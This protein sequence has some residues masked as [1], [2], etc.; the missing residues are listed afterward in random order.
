MKE[1]SM[2][3]AIVSNE[4]RQLWRRPSLWIVQGIMAV[5]PL[6]ALLVLVFSG[7][8][9]P[10]AS[11]DF[12]IPGTSFL[13]L[14]FLIVPIL[15]IPSLKQDQGAIGEILWSSPVD[16]LVHFCAKWLGLWLGLI[17]GAALQL[18]GW[19]LLD[20]FLP[21]VLPEWIW[22]V[23]LGL[24]LL[25]N[26]VGLSLITFLAAFLRSSLAL[27]IAW[28]VVWVWLFY[29]IYFSASLS[30]GFNPMQSM[31]FNNV[32]FS[33][34]VISPSLGLGLSQARV[35][36]MAAWFAG[37]SL[38]AAALGLGITLILDRRQSPRRP[39]SAV[40]LILAGV[41]AL[42]VGFSANNSI[43]AAHDWATSPYDPQVDE[44]RV[45]SQKTD[46][47]IDAADRRISGTTQ[48]V[49]MP[50]KADGISEIVLKLNPGLELTTR[51]GAKDE[52][53]NNLVVRRTGDSVVI[54]V[55]ESAS[56]PYTLDLAWQ[57]K[58]NIPYRAFEMPWKHN[59]APGEYRYT[60][61][62][63]ALQALL[64]RR[65]SFLLRDGDW[66]P[67]PWTTSSH[68]ADDNQVTLRL[69]GRGEM[70][71]ADDGL[72]EGDPSSGETISYQGTLP[73]ALAVVLPKKPVKG[74]ASTSMVS[75]NHL[76]HAR[77][78][79]RTTEQL[80]ALL[81]TPA[82]K[83][84]VVTPYL[85]DLVWSG[86]LLLVPDGSGYYLARPVSWLY[87]LDPNGR[88]YNVVA[89]TT[90]HTLLRAWM[91]QQ[92]SEDGTGYVALLTPEGYDS[93]QA[94]LSAT[95]PEEWERDKGH[96]LQI[97]EKPD[98]LTSWMPRKQTTL[99]SEGEWSSLAFW[100]AMEMADEQTRQK[101]LELI[102]IFLG[103]VTKTIGG[104][105]RYSM[106]RELLWP[107]VMEDAAAQQMALSLH[108]WAESVGREQA[109]E[110]VFAQLRQT[111]ADDFDG[112]VAELESLSGQPIDRREE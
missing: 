20:L 87:Q 28:V 14:Q 99:T 69:A 107:Y 26:T 23:S 75:S 48:L 5:L 112:F 37:V 108:E 64:D 96:W 16:A 17:P 13:V 67:W 98:Y 65:I 8:P 95:N 89:R 10:V 78:F 105:D 85:S 55:P 56:A 88:D 47:E 104:G 111:K 25:V 40:V 43:R 62:P 9:T 11:V 34:L 109:V 90:M 29:D 19:F 91:L 36:G 81:D 51:L 42:L 103:D 12:G 76:E 83:T 46:V 61:M 45:L 102:E 66:M 27:A 49:L 86:D 50:E 33:N 73:E 80:A 41:L 77:L 60:F 7:S 106:M 31:A 4:V 15:V 70:L 100:L 1:L 74:I 18:A 3:R 52:N 32:F 94:R 58:L 54:P 2:F 110:L 63:A 6:V 72:I 24:Y 71:A 93:Q 57:G 39:G 21:N 84:I 53:E 30:E 92:W 68:Q 79:A 35:L 59:E 44:W 82:P 22:L 101:D 97:T 38:A